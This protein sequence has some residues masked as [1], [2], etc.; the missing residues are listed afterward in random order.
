M[1][2]GE[3]PEFG[4]LQV[5]RIGPVGSGARDGPVGGTYGLATLADD[6]TSGGGRHADVGF[7]LHLFFGAEEVF[8]LQFPKDPPLRL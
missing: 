6:A 3:Q 7:Q 1:V 5:L 2:D 8:F 4:T